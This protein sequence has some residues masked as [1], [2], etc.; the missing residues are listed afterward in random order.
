MKNN[1]AIVIPYFKKTYLK[2]LLDSLENQTNKNFNVY[3]GNDC[4]PND[5]IDIINQYAHLIKTYK[6]Y[7]NNVGSKN[8]NLHWNRCIDDLVQD[9]EWIMILCDDDLLEY[10]VVESFYFNLNKIS[11]NDLNVV[12]YATRIVNEDNTQVLSEYTSKFQIENSLDLFELKVQDKTRS[13]LS[14]YIFK[15]SAYKKFKFK[16]F[17]LS[18]GS[19]NVAWLEFSN[20]SSIFCINDSFVKYR[21]SVLSVSGNEKLKSGKMIGEIEF[22]NYLIINHKSRFSKNLLYKIYE[23]YFH[24]Y[25]SINYTNNFKI[26]NLIK[27]MIIDL[28]LVKTL[29]LIKNNKYYFKKIYQ[30]S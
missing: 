3:I 25:R 12:R 21:N 14:E 7:P 17:N 22:L 29:I 2:D 23:R 27:N 18:F 6:T 16:S 30:P 10:N 8:L 28:G 20:F 4:S 1:L 19:D 9:E 15:Y 13:S 26:L 5:P 11:D 24:Y